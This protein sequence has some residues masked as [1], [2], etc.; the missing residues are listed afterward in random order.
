MIS[1]FRALITSMILLTLTACGGGGSL[2]RDSSGGGGDTPTETTFSVSLSLSD[3]SG[4][5]SNVLSANNPLV[6]TATVTDQNGDVV[7]NEDVSFSISVDDLAVFAGSVSIVRTNAS[8]VAIVTLEV[9]SLAGGAFVVA[10]VGTNTT[11]QIGF[12]SQGPEQTVVD[13]ASLE[14]FTSS[15]QLA[16]SGSDSIELVAVVKN[17]QNVLLEGV[18]VSFSVNSGNLQI[19]Q[20]TTTADGTARATLSTTNNPQNRV[21][22]ATARTGDFVETLDIDVVGTGVNISGPSSVIINDPVPLT[23]IVADSDGVGIANQPVSLTTTGGTID[24]IAPVTGPTGQVQVTFTA[25]SSGTDVVTASSLNAEGSISLI[26]QEDEFGFT[27]L[28]TEEIPLGEDAT[29]EVTWLKESLPFE[30][31]NVVFT[32]SRGDIAVPSVVTNAEGQAS[33]TISSDNAGLASISAEGTDTDGNTVTTR[34]QIEFIATVP[35]TIIV[36]GTP[37]SIGPDGQTSTITAVVRDATGNLVKGQTV[38]FR[39]EDTSGGSLS[40]PTAVTDGS[41]IASVIYTSNAVSSQ[42]FVRVFAEVSDNTSITDFTTLTV[43]DRAFDITLGTGREI[44]SP[45]EA[46]YLKEFAVFVS[47]ADSNPV[48]NASLSVASTPV[49]FNLGGVYRKGVWVWDPVAEIWEPITTI[50]CPN[51]D[52]NGNG[53]LDAGEDTNNDGLLTPGN[54]AISSD[55]VITDDNGQATVEI[56]YPKQFGSWA[57]IALRV[58][59]QSNGSESVQSQDFTLTVAASDVTEESSPPPRN[60]FGTIAD[61]SVRPD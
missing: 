28:P 55:E 5:E 6:V 19:T 18:A 38:N 29:L 57:D 13:P 35:S 34:A 46:S 7:A 45:D 51:E 59:G 33:I 50:E 36:D 17:E 37:D 15:I 24:N 23:I 54:V 52:I 42:D 58:S 14:F 20:G 43:G 48:S 26:V 16:S 31:G 10:S 49:K 32:S 47:D 8:G 22:T 60:P 39:V 61:C 44:Q 9:G 41:G 40:S 3:S 4:A 56:R 27:T 30:N 2:E 1:S 53:I 11:A 25:S 21:I 12:N